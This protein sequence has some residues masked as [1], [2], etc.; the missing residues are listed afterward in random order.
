[1]PPFR[2]SPLTMHTATTQTSNFLLALCSLLKS[3]DRSSRS[4]SSCMQRK[5]PSLTTSSSL[6]LCRSPPTHDGAMD[7]KPCRADRSTSSHKIMRLETKARKDAHQV[8]NLVFS[9]ERRQSKTP[10]LRA[11][12][13][14]HVLHDKSASQFPYHKICICRSLNADLPPAVGGGLQGGTSWSMRCG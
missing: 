7:G 9:H 11:S 1:M 5:S 3:F 10:T 14:T 12:K 4:K 13:R 6:Y 8:L 2:S